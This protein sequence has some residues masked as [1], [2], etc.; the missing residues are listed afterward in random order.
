[1]GQLSLI[2]IGGVIRE[3]HTKVQS[4]HLKGRNH[5]GGL[6]YKWKHILYEMRCEGVVYT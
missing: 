4:R 2:V 1:M 3:T 6:R 5:L